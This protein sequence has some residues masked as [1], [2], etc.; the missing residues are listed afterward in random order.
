LT[1]H[2]FATAGTKSYMG[3]EN[4]PAQ[5]SC[6]SIFPCRCDPMKKGRLLK[7]IA[8][9][10]QCPERACMSPRVHPLQDEEFAVAEEGWI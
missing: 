3:K 7:P 1:Q 2:H 4:N 5:V 8:F 10:R 9:R 6:T